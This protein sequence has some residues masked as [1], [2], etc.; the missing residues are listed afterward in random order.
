MAWS[1]TLNMMRIRTAV[2][3][4]KC[5]FGRFGRDMDGSTAIEFAMVAGPLFF[6]IGCII[7][8]GTMLFVEY[9][10]Q[11][12]V[13]EAG[14]VLR[15]GQAQTMSGEDFKETICSRTAAIRACNTSLGLYVESANS[16]RDLNNPPAIMPRDPLTVIPGVTNV[17]DRGITQQAVSVIA[18]Y[19]WTFV[20]PFMRPLSN[21][22][23]SNVRRLHGITVFRNEPA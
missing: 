7:E 1:R 4:N 2:Q 19:D 21:I 6:L 23:G 18:T 22:T 11:N 5:R 13:Q 16:F 8:L 3:G 20:F 12:A 9:T 15:T 17:F 10:L 14:R